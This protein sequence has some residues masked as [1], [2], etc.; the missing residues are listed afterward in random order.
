M[1]VLTEEADLLYKQHKYGE[2]AR[3]YLKLAESSA[4]C[5]QKTGFYRR[6]AEAYHE[7]GSFDEE[8]ACLQKTCD[9]L[10]GEERIDC[11]IS[12]FNVYILAIAVY[13]YDTGFEWKG[14]PENLQEGYGE[15]IRN[16]YD[17]AVSVL[18]VVR[19]ET[20]D[21]RGL[22]KKLSILCDRRQSEDGWGAD[23]CW[24]AIREAWK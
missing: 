7:L 13:Q 1:I 4:D 9:L 17:K 10:Q 6:A 11:L 12:M 16:Y 15:T 24:Q 22:I 19:V 14:E 3:I 5:A 18:K 8:T 23:H 20:T 2:A 21:E